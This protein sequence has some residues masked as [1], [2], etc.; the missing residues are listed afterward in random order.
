LFSAFFKLALNLKHCTPHVIVHWVYNRQICRPLVLCD[1]IWTVLC[2]AR[3]VC[4]CAVLLENESDGQQ[5]IAVFK[6]TL[7]GL[8][9]ENLGGRRTSASKILLTQSF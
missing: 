3:G 2:T 4:W 8:C 6:N 9:Q 5:V 1:K 7:K